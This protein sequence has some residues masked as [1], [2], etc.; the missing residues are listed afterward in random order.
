[1]TN[2]SPTL[3]TSLAGVRIGLL[4]DSSPEIRTLEEALIEH[5]AFIERIH[6][7]APWWT[8][9]ISVDLTIVRVERAQTASARDLR[10]RRRLDLLQTLARTGRVIAL[11]DEPL[12]GTLSEFVLP[13]FGPAEVISRIFRALKEPRPSAS[14]RVGNVELNIANRIITVGG[15]VVDL[16]FNEFEIFRILL[17]ANGGVLSREDLNRRLG[18]DEAAQKSRR[19]DIHIHRLRTKLHGMTG[20]TVDTVRNVGY[21]LTV[22][23][24]G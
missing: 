11:L 6:P 2:S 5:G 9:E 20:A 19:V 18:G 10:G 22:S 17:A 1:M 3:H 4:A 12:E 16:T 24:I 23:R 8:S 7:D 15:D 13:P 14:I 21:R